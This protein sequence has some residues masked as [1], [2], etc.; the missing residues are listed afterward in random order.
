VEQSK[1]VQAK[2]EK[3][4]RDLIDV[5]GGDDDA[6]AIVTKYQ[7]NVTNPTPGSSPATAKP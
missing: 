4:A 6:K 3:L 5:A 2:L 1:E 7:I